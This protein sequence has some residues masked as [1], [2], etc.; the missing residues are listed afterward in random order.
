[1]SKTPNNDL[2][3]KASTSSVSANTSAI[4]AINGRIKGFYSFARG[5]GT[6]MIIDWYPDA[7]YIIASNNDSTSGNFY[8]LS[9]YN[10]FLCIINQIETESTHVHLAFNITSDNKL[11]ITNSGAW[12]TILKVIIV[13][14]EP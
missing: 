4:N 14:Y 11:K 2:A 13:N 1:M 9:S 12:G 8:L 6:D 7:L 3:G 10:N 5:M